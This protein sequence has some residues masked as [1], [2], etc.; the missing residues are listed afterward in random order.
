M[1]VSNS[2]TPRIGFSDSWLRWIA[3]QGR[4]TAENAS[5]PILMSSYTDETG[6]LDPPSNFR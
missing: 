1:G 2:H 4:N 3:S 5:C 6:W